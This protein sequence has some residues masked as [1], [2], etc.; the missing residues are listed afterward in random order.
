MRFEAILDVASNTE[1]SFRSAN[2][3]LKSVLEHRVTAHLPF[4]ARGSSNVL[5]QRKGPDRNKGVRFSCRELPELASL[6]VAVSKVPPSLNAVSVRHCASRHSDG[7]SLLE[8][9][10]VGAVPTPY[11]LLSHPVALFSFVPKDA[12]IFVAGAIAGAIAKTVT[13]PLD[14]VKLLVQV[15]TAQAVKSSSKNL[16]ALDAFIQI[17]KEDGIK[18][19][20]KGNLPQV[21]RIIPYSA[22]QLFAYE[23]YK[24][25]FQGDAK[26]LSVGARLAAGGC[27]G[28]TSTLVTYP[29]DVLRLRMAIDPGSITVRGAALKML[30]EE[31]VL[32]FYKGLGPSLISIAPYIALNFCAFDLIKK[33]IPEKYRKTP[34]ASFFT[35]MCATSFATIMCYPLDTV[36]RQ[37]QMKN[38]PFTSLVD[39]IP[40]IV[41][42]DGV[43]GLYRGFIANALKNLP[44]SSIRL[45]TYDTAKNL[46]THSRAVFD[47]LVE[48]RNSYGEGHSRRGP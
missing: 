10:P 8:R 31:G 33:S 38:S 48:E 47:Q 30:T 14:R 27:A 39:A 11:Q 28:M 5:K 43:P 46:I 3:R 21:I 17:G 19:Y 40:G 41:A 35:A 2:E 23:I 34:Q 15:H 13:A 25:L 6:S 22:V 12:S 1:K 44:N 36:R 18:G 9:E 42:R 24:K 37:L 29:L 20:W 16:S 32:A 45:M 26:E 4:G 7:E